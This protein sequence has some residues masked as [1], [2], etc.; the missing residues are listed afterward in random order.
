MWLHWQPLNRP[1]HDP[2]NDAVAAFT[3]IPTVRS[4]TDERISMRTSAAI[5]ALFF[6]FTAPA[7]A[8]E[9]EELTKAYFKMLSQQQW[10]EIAKLYDPVS[11]KEFRETMSFLAEVPDEAAARVLGGFFGPGATKASVQALSDQAFFSF[12][13][14]GIMAQA[15]QLGELDIRKVQVLGSVAEG[16]ALRHVVARTKIG[17]GE[18]SLEAMEVI[19]FKKQ[20]DRWAIL[21]QGKFKG[22]VPR[23]KKALES[24]R[25]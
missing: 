4:F 8:A 9:P 14:R 5:L 13:L 10:D 19:S 24:L 20:G 3:T 1:F 22:L 2:L 7:L 6:L 18:M 15:A 25:K 21:M 17:L 11:L 23:L 16:D 12:F